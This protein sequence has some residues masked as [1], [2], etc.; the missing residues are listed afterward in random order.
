MPINLTPIFDA[1]IKLCAV[2]I[3]SVLVPW[4][5]VHYGS[6]RADK[7]MKWARVAVQAAEQIYGANAGKEKAEYVKQYLSER[8]ITVNEAE[9]RAALEAA[10]Y[11]MNN[12]LT[13]RVDAIGFDAEGDA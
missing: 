7:I 2:A 8:G 11:E 5:Y 1:L 13:E 10:V 9:I 12:A 6:D 4:L 3:T